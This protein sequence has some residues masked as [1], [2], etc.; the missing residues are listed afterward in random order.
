MRHKVYLPLLCIC[1]ILIAAC[2]SGSQPSGS[3]V[4]FTV[5]KNYFIKNNVSSIPQPELDNTAAFNEIFGMASTTGEQGRPTAIDFD[6][7][8]VIAIALPE[9]DTATTIEPVRLAY[10]KQKELVYSYR[11]R[12][13]EELGFRIRPSLVIIVDK[14]NKGKLF[15]KQVP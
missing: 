6:K 8:Y 12:R 13:E 7:Q 3:E 5:A 14:S 1:L 9:T 2:G 10:N 4:P 11:I 15:M